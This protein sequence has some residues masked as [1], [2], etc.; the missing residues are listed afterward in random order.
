ME[1]AVSN[2]KKQNITPFS[3]KER[4]LCEG[5]VV[6]FRR[7]GSKRWQARIKRSTGRWVVYSTGQADITAAKSAAE[8]RYR[9]IKYAQE[10]GRVDVTRRFRSVCQLCRN[11]L[12]AE[13]ERTQKDLPKDLV[14]VID[15]YII[16]IL[17]DYMCHNVAQAELKKFSIKRSEML[18]RNPSSSTV[19]T[20][21]TAL[22]YIFRKAKELNYIEFI[23]KT[24]NDGD[25]SFKRRPYFN[26]K[27]LRIL[28]ANMWR[29][30]QHGEKLLHAKGKNGIDTISQ[31]TYWI[32]ELL[33]D[34]VLILVN[35]GMR[36]GREMLS[37]KCDH[38]PRNRAMT[39]MRFPISLCI[40]RSQDEEEA[41]QRR[42]NYWCHQAA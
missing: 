8:N 14:Q 4:T 36:P 18:G 15:K 20:H 16:P 10:M 13:A 28:N 38:S 25:A 39:R 19:A 33:S 37:I 41:L 11:E 29:Y 34:V 12:L 17:G 42:A 27:E 24:I 5:N 7:K 31:K 3:T 6:L 2:S 23:P 9:D 40:R 1:S 26:D 21:N 30:L 35:T 22:N 32:R